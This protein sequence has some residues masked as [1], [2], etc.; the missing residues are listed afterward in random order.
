MVVNTDAHSPADLIDQE[1]AVQIA[2]GAGL[3]W[4]EARKIVVEHAILNK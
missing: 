1:R 2:F 3:D 4:E